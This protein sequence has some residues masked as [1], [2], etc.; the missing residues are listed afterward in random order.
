M[1]SWRIVVCATR[2]GQRVPCAASVLRR[3]ALHSQL[4]HSGAA[5]NAKAVSETRLDMATLELKG[6]REWE[7][8]QPDEGRAGLTAGEVSTH[9]PAFHGASVKGP[10]QSICALLGCIPGEAMLW[11]KPTSRNSGQQRVHVRLLQE[12]TGRMQHCPE[13]RDSRY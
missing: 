7:G 10:K 1:M 9:F 13:M 5:R 8:I 3:V 6:L 12:N 4:K 11:G 2:T